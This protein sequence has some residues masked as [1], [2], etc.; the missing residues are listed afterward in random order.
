MGAI[1]LLSLLVI[2]VAAP[3]P[4]V[5]ATIVRA[6]IAQPSGL[7]GNAPESCTVLAQTPA[8]EPLEPVA[9]PKDEETALDAHV[10]LVPKLREFYAGG[11]GLAGIFG[12]LFLMIGPL[13]IV[14]TFVKLTA[15]ADDAL[16]KQLA[17]RGFLISTVSILLAALF[18]QKLL[19]K[20][21][22]SLSAIVASAGLV[23]FLV[24]LRI[25]MS[26]YGADEPS[27]PPPEKP[28]L[29][30]AIQPLAFPAILTPYGIAAV[31][32]V[33]TIEGRLNE[34]NTT[35]ILGMI[36]AIAVLDWLAMLYA[37]QIL[38]FLKPR[39]LQVVGLV[40]GIIQLSLGL[41]LI[42]AAVELEALVIQ[43]LLSN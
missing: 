32:T 12:I 11:S 9:V 1:A 43:Q 34:G 28:S 36:V 17:F 3:Q 7:C 38:N 8:A 25:V 27:D 39:V 15:N 35:T 19:A 16:R 42:F 37:R 40:L 41:G 22:I 13:K 33:M 4:L 18:G 23:L 21:Q 20:Y 29:A 26:Q 2:W 31:M 10:D 24:A 30:L 5:R 14:P 6:T